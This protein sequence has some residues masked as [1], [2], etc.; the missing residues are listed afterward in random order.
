MEEEQELREAEVAQE[1]EL[2]KNKQGEARL[3]TDDNKR[4]IQSLELL[5]ENLQDQISDMETNRKASKAET[6]TN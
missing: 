3:Q 4:K 1:R 5:V 2:L 6:E